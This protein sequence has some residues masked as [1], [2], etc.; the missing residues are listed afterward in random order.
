MEDIKLITIKETAYRLSISRATLY[1]MINRGE[2][3][4]PIQI[5]S[6]GG[7][8]RFKEEDIDNFL[9]SKLQT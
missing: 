4:K 2:L 3:P 6:C 9:A 1:R 8:P 7:C 5:T